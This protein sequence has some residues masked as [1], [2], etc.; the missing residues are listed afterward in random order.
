[1]SSYE[2]D[3]LK[4]L[5]QV[6]LLEK[7]VRSI[8]TKSRLHSGLVWRDAILVSSNQVEYIMTVVAWFLSKNNLFDYI[9]YIYI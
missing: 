4:D 9:V 2:L 1:M 8:F 5:T 7:G 3:F 6:F